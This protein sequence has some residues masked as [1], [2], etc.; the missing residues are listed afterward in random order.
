[1]R[2]LQEQ[3]ETSGRSHILYIATHYCKLCSNSWPAFNILLQSYCSVALLWCFSLMISLVPGKR[4]AKSSWEIS[5]EDQTPTLSATLLRKTHSPTHLYTPKHTHTHMQFH[6]PM[7][8]VAAGWMT[9]LWTVMKR[10]TTVRWTR[11]LQ[12]PASTSAVRAPTQCFNIT[13][14]LKHFNCVLNVFYVFDVLG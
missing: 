1:M 10:W 4:A 14:V 6:T 3:Q 13:V 5:L 8:D 12:L 2:S 9:S 7:S 11:W